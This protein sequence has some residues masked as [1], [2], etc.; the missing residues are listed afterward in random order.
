MTT[1]EMFVEEV[2]IDVALVGRLV[3]A[4]FPNGQ[5]FPSSQ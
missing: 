2:Y 3:I 1:G 4:R 5:T